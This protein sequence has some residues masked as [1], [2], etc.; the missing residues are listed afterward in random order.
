MFAA[1]KLSRDYW[2]LV[3][4]LA[5]LGLT[6]GSGRD[7]LQS[8]IIVRPIAVLLCFYG[9]FGLTRVKWLEHRASLIWLGLTFLFVLMYL[10]PLPPSLWQNAPGH[11]L[12]ADIDQVAGLGDIWRSYSV[13]PLRT[14][15]ALF[16]LTIPTAVLLLIIRIDREERSLLLLPVIMFGIVSVALALLQAAAPSAKMLWLY[17]L[18]N[19]AIPVGLFANRNHAAIFHATLV[20]M[21]AILVQMPT[22]IEIWARIRVG[23]VVML[24]M[25]ALVAVFASGSRAGLVCAVV[26]VA[27]L[28]LLLRDLSASARRSTTRAKPPGF[29][30]IFDPGNRW[31]VISATLLLVVAMGALAFSANAPSG[32]GQRLAGTSESE[33]RWEIWQRS[34]DLAKNYAPL[35][36]G[37]GTFVEV[38]KI[39]EPINSLG[40]NY[41]NHAHNDFIETL[42]TTG[43]VGFLYLAAFLLALAR[44]GWR[45]MKRQTFRAAWKQN[46]ARMAW[47][48]L[49]TFGLASVVDYPL[50]VPSLL[51]VAVIMAYWA[52]AR[53]SPNA[54][55]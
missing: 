5:L 8:L 46:Q 37:P 49:A 27:G 19:D 10:V 40:P 14:L 2:V 29:G 17:R 42:L 51:A 41:I 53:P 28:P 4:F 6:A 38:Y 23:V 47:L 20:P 48:V 1:F 54:A 25:A 32:T 34:L 12:I 13:A 7:D 55:R 15:N 26:A 16:A 9:A 45:L 44:V 18:T 30:K 39:G 22:R 24:G 35:G 31:T 43:V 52:T 11:R 36:S 3:A 21:L 33:L 50:R